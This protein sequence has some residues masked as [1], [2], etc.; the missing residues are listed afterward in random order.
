[1]RWLIF[2]ALLTGCGGDYVRK[3]ADTYQPMFGELNLITPYKNSICMAGIKHDEG[4]RVE[5]FG[6]D[7]NV[8]LHGVDLMMEGKINSI[9]RFKS[10]WAITT[11]K[12]DSTYLSDNYSINH[13]GLRGFVG[14]N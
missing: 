6:C 12:G 5:F 11:D 2:L 7:T 3:D 1:M 9:C 13:N 8:Y 10:G 4:A 14:C